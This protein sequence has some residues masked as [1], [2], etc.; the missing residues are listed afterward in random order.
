MYMFP[1]LAECGEVLSFCFNCPTVSKGPFQGL[2]SVRFFCLF[3]C[4]CL[5]VLF[6]LFLSISVRSVVDFTVS[7]NPSIVAKCCFVFLIAR[8]L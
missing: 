8:R 3:V 7:N 4:F 1:A 2:L 5:L 6:V